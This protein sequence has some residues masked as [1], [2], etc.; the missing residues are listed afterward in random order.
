MYF[1]CG[2]VHI[3]K[4]LEK[5][6]VSYKLQPSLLTQEMDH[7]NIYEDTWK[8]KEHDWL[9]YL[10]IDLLSTAFNYARYAKGMEQ[11][12]G[13]G[14]KNSLTLPCIATKFFESLRKEHD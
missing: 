9:P 12:T 11:F 7:H 6:G 4:L 1:R 3:S 5:I 2:R 10:K 8:D 13:Y 14:K